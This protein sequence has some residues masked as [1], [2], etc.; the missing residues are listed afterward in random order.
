M[1]WE[2][3]FNPEFTEDLPLFNLALF[4]RGYACLVR[5][6][7]YSNSGKS[8]LGGANMGEIR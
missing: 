5:D 2:K 8:T 7:A 1:V 6:R 4:G 3:A